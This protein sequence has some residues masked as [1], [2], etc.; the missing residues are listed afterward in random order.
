MCYEKAI[1][2]FDCTEDEFEQQKESNKLPGE[3][4][5]FIEKDKVDWDEDG[6]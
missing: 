5:T 2:E 1:I 6:N 3:K 4:W